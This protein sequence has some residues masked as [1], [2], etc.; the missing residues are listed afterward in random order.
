MYP[1]IRKTN[2]KV[3]IRIVFAHKGTPVPPE[4]ARIASGGINSEPLTQASN[5][6]FLSAQLQQKF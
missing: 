1:R 2:K 5:R 3:N 4:A 6:E